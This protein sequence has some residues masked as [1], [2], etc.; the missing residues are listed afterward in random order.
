[1][2]PQGVHGV[3]VFT[4]ESVFE[5][6]KVGIIAIFVLLKY[7]IKLA[8]VTSDISFTSVIPWQI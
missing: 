7:E 4:I 3:L 5:T 2:F 8:L 1:M 6:P